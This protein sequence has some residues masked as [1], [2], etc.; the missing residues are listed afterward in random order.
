MDNVLAQSIKVGN[1][2]PLEINGPLVGI[3]KLSD[4]F[5]VVFSFLF[6]FI[7]IVL[8]VQF[9]YSG[10]CLIRS[11]GDPAKI[12]DAKYRMTYAV[13]GLFILVSSFLITKLVAY[14]LGFGG[15]LF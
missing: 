2:S 14:I 12:K 8:L 7:G 4:V 15:D 11:D 5:N 6:P 13:L 10:Y 9:F 3:S 1:K